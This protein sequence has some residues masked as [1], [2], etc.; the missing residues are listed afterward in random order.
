MSLQGIYDA[1]RQGVWQD[2]N[3]SRCGCGGRG[4]YLSDVDTWHLCSLHGL[5]APCPEDETEETF[6]W[7]A[8]YRRNNV[9]AFRSFREAARAE[10]W[11]GSNLQ[12]ILACRD[13]LRNLGIKPFPDQAD[14]VNAAEAM[15][16]KAR[17]DKAAR[18]E[19]AYWD[20][21]HAAWMD[22]P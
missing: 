9:N 14:W 5:N 17:Q 7:R 4:W 2:E 3:P 11:E 10:G 13:I 6:D 19:Q 20:R 15:I 16:E 21:E 1:A 12:F 8:H 22:R 18:E